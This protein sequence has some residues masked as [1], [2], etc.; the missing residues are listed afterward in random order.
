MRKTNKSSLI[1]TFLTLFIIP[2]SVN[3]FSLSCKPD[4]NKSVEDEFQKTIS[5][6]A[7]LELEINISQG[8][9]NITRGNDKELKINSKYKVLGTKEEELKIIAE[10]IKKDPPI[11]IK[12]NKIKIGNLKKYNIDGWFSEEKVIMD[13]DIYAPAETTVIAETGLGNINITSLGSNVKAITGSGSI[14]I[15]NAKSANAKTGSGYVKIVVIANDVNVIAGKGTIELAML[16]GNINAKTGYGDITIN[17][18]IN[19]GKKWI[20]DSG[21]GDVELK[22]SPGS[23]FSFSCLTGLGKVDFKIKGEITEKTEK[24]VE[25]KVGTNP[26]SSLSIKVGKGDIMIEES[27][28]SISI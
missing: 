22:L 27:I 11:D 10:N 25:G 6:S 20:L 26:T 4:L 15:E 13:L 17:S 16:N 19:E 8:N 23:T 28:V 3:N 2:L 5:I 12:S 24:K 1:A 14:K 9:I 21:I 7:P 18:T